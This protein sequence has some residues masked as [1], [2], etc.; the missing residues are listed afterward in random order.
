[1]A[2]NALEMNIALMEKLI[3]WCG[4]SHFALCLGSLYI[5]KALKWK[6]HLATLHPLLKQM[7]WTYAGYI[8]A[9]NLTFGIISV[10]GPAELLDGSF[11]AKAIT[12]M[13]GIY[14]L[15]RIGIQFFY[16]D[17]SQAPKGFVFLLGEIA[18]VGLF[19]LFTVTYLAA[20]LI[21]IEWL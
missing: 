16:F 7:F 10:F 3:I 5:P 18:L 13:I 14:W 21:N 12:L 20:F 6:T 15:T 2:L 19:V 8:L 9:I 11:L 1:M 4:I 17:R